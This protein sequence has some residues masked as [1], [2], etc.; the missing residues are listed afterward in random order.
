MR[1]TSVREFVE[2]LLLG[3]C[4]ATSSSQS[5]VAELLGF[6]QTLVPELL[7]Q[8]GRTVPTSQLYR[9][10]LSANFE[11]CTAA[12]VEVAEED[13]SGIAQARAQTVEST[14]GT[15]PRR[16][17]VSAVS[18][19]PATP[20]TSLSPIGMPSSGPPSPFRGRPDG[21]SCPTAG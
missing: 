1:T 8:L 11:H 15:F 4:P 9:L 7:L 13:H 5:A 20:I 12:A 18:G 14:G 10:A 19:R 2:L 17:A 6:P 21:C 16:T 3:S